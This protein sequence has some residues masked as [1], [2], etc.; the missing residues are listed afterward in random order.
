MYKFPDNGWTRQKYLGNYNKYIAFGGFDELHTVKY[1]YAKW[2]FY[3]L[4]L[5]QLTQH[6]FLT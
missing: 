3:G 2:E 1:C 5:G 6:S 4:Q